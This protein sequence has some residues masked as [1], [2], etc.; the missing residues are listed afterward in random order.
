M[1]FFGDIIIKYPE[2]LKE[3]PRDAIILHWGY[4]VDF[5]FDEHCCLL[6]EAGLPF[7]VLPS[8]SAYNSIGGR[9]FRTMGNI[10][11]AAFNGLKHGALGLLNTEWGDYGHWHTWSVS[12]LGFAYG[13]AM[14]WGPNENENIDIKRALDLFVFNDKASVMGRTIFELGNCYLRTR[15]YDDTSNLYMTMRFA[16]NSRNEGPFRE[17]SVDGLEKTLEDIDTAMADFDKADMVMIPEQVKLVKNEIRYA[18]K[19]L[20]FTCRAGI[21]LLKSKAERFVSLDRKDK[22]V[23]SEQLYPLMQLHCENWLKSNRIGGLKD[24]LLWYG[25]LLNQLV[26]DQKRSVEKQIN[27]IISNTKGNFK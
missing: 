8:N 19:M 4:G 9:T 26:S 7:Y 25:F 16:H 27:E 11:N 1:M 10:R 14:A 23:L 6:K 18:A 21:T 3:L 15:G 24:S 5:P 17:L 12:C 2:L 22:D 13:A 20:R